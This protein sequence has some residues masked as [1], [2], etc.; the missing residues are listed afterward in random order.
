MKRLDK[1]LLLSAIAVALTLAFPEPAPAQPVSASAM[2]FTVELPQT[3]PTT[4][5]LQA[6]QMLSQCMGKPPWEYKCDL[7][8]GIPN[9][10]CICV[11][12]KEC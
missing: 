5:K 7:Y 4:D 11:P 2:E 8:E 1:L 9:W 6:C 10:R 12:Q 3:T